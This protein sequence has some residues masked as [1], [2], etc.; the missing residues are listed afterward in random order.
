M[1]DP[2]LADCA[3]RHRPAPEPL[4]KHR[5]F[6]CGAYSTLT[7]TNNN[8]N[9]SNKK[10]NKNKNKKKLRASGEGPLALALFLFGT[11]DAEIMKPP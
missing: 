4:K 5:V 11:A 8:D 3:R 7:A 9:K 1:P 6:L 2:P 10:K